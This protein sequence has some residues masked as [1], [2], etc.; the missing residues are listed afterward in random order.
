MTL[1]NYKQQLMQKLDDGS[2]PGISLD[3]EF[4][5]AC[6][7]Q[8]M[9]RCCNTITILLDP[10]D[11]EIMAR[12]LGIS[13][14]EFVAEYCK[15]D[16]GQGLK[17]PY[18]RLKHAEDGPCIFMLPGGRCEI[19]PV[20]SRN[21]RTYP[22]GRAVRFEEKGTK[23]DKIFMIEKMDFCLGHNCDQPWTVKK[24]FEDAQ[25]QK[26]YELSDLYLEV[27]D[28]ATKQLDSPRW[29][30][31]NIAQ[32][33]M[34]LLYGPD[35]LRQKLS[36]SEQEVDHEEFYRRRMKALKVILTDIAAEFGYG[37]CARQK[38]SDDSPAMPGGSLMDRMKVVLITGK[39]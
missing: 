34:P 26:F 16:F 11:V 6:K 24:W 21:C 20:R 32:M 23:R 14:R 35:L 2:L 17:W 4:T 30:N 39:E 27:I 37:P 36:I 8:C 9:G 5:F 10:W 28:Y 29:M 13:G 22:I 18:V 7:D 31:R 15:Y 25:C 3:H 33:L 12:H 38:E 1:H 19:Y